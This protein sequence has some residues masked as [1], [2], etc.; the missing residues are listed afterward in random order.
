MRD[1]QRGERIRTD[2]QLQ[3]SFLDPVVPAGSE[4]TVTGTRH[5]MFESYVQVEFDNGTRADLEMKP[6]HF[7]RPE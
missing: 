6:G 5:D 4:G 1:F 7:Q 3:G 2:E